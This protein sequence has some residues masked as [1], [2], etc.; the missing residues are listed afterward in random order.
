MNDAKSNKT[1]GYKGFDQSLS[2]DKYLDGISFSE[3]N[4]NT[5]K[6]HMSEMSLNSNAEK[7]VDALANK[8]KQ[9]DS[10]H[11]SDDPDFWME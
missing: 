7:K 8:A 9:E 4:H 3:S 11:D 6:E 5:M 1:L 10:V 2:E